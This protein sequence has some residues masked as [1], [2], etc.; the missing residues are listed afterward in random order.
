MGHWGL[1]GCFAALQIF[2]LADF[3]IGRGYLC[4][5]QLSS[6][7]SV[8]DAAALLG[9]EFRGNGDMLITGIN[10]IHKV[11]PGDLTFVDVQKYYKK[12]FDSAA[13]IILINQDTAFPKGKAIII[14]DDP[15]T[16]YNKLVT[17]FRTEEKPGSFSH[18]NHFASGKN[19]K[20]GEN[21]QIFPGVVLGN[22][23]TIG[24]N[25]TLFPNVVLYDDTILGDNV[26]IQANSV[27]GGHAYYF[28]NRK[29]HFEKLISCG[30]TIIENNVEI[31][32]GCTID[33]GVSGDT[34]IGEHTKLDNQVHVGHGVVI[35]KRCL[36]GA[37]VVIGGKTI[38]EDDV[39]IWGQAAITK[40]ITI[41]ARAVISGQSGVTKSIPGDQ[42]YFGTPAQEIRKAQKEMAWVRRGAKGE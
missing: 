10:E 30:R 14:S 39:I 15:F 28:K 3:Q 6:P 5:M 21:V 35:G 31:G 23:I 16:D 24:N 2:K 11:T 18:W 13:T 20:I 36:I 19:V 26:I 38:I 29:T 42:A 1:R 9:A 37:A 34:I 25:C 12:A 4:S 41:G 8:R 17:H 27:I 32:A 33:K 7:I 40:D 22:N